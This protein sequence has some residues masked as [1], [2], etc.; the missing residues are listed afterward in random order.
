MPG[1]GLRIAAA[2]CL[3][4]RAA[5]SDI[6]EVIDLDGNGLLSLEEY[7]F[8]EQ[9]TSGEKCDEDAW[10]VC[11]GDLTLRARAAVRSCPVSDRL[12]DRRT[13]RQTDRQMGS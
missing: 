3:C 11:R 4:H 5:L 9:R 7:N 10:A 13:G 12:T 1:H 8:F 2:P 6:F